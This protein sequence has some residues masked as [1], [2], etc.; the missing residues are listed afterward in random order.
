MHH[1]HQTDFTP[2]QHLQSDKIPYLIMGIPSL[3]PH[4][5][6]DTHAM[7]GS[8]KLRHRTSRFTRLPAE[9]RWQ[10]YDLLTIPSDGDIQ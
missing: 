7:E 9:L 6:L 8:Q 5:L 10:V 2:M 1:R 3:R 4:N